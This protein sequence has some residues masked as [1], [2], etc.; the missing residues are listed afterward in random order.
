MILSR[1][2]MI[3]RHRRRTAEN[4]KAAAESPMFGI[5]MAIVLLDEAVKSRRTAAGRRPG[6]SPDEQAKE[7][8]GDD[9]DTRG[10]GGVR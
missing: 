1:L 4:V 9:Q 5:G 6:A 3:A 7:G 8:G 10:P 2:R